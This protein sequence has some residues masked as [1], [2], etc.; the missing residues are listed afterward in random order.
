MEW[1]KEKDLPIHSIS[2]STLKCG[3][4]DITEAGNETTGSRDEYNEEKL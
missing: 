4:V 1:Y 2:Y 3:G